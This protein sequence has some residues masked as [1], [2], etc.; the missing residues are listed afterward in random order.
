[1]NA[2]DVGG[3]QKIRTMVK[4][5]RS[6]GEQINHQYIDQTNKDTKTPHR[7]QMSST[8]VTV[9]ES[10]KPR[11]PLSQHSTNVTQYVIDVY[12]LK[13]N[14]ENENARADSFSKIYETGAWGGG[15]VIN[16]EKFGGSGPGSLMS[17]TE[18]VRKTLDIIIDEI[19]AETGKER[20]SLLDMPC[21]DM[22]WM[23]HYLEQ[24]MD[25][26]YTGMDIVG[27]LIDHHKNASGGEHP[28]RFKQH[29]IVKDPLQERYD[30]IFSR[31]M[32]QHL[33]TEDTMQ[34][35][36][37]FSDGGNYLLIT[38]YPGVRVNVPLNAGTAWRF[39]EQNFLI[40]PYRLIDP[41]CEGDEDGS[42]V[43]SFYRLP[44]LQ[45]H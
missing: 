13:M 1:L 10:N 44:L 21:G 19:K 40:E 5:G 43:I 36:H 41:I 18:K 16:G 38:N 25:V 39:R 6:S 4:S 17:S 23:R 28:W 42:D 26:D 8:H 32:T 9:C 29:D 45:W 7:I 12:S 15:E 34:V 33:G 22:V 37:H 3:E 24:R 11:R 31:Q 14:Q 30:L 27:S 2:I 35:L 20:I